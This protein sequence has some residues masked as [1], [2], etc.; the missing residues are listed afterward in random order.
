MGRLLLWAL[1][2]LTLVLAGVFLFFP[3][4]AYRFS[5]RVWMA[6]RHLNQTLHYGLGYQLPGTPDLK[7]LDPRLAEKGFKRGAPIFIRIIKSELRLE[8]W[9]KRGERF[10]KFASYPICYWSGRLGPKLKTGDHQAPEGFYTVSRTQLNPNS[11][12]HRSFNL[13]FPN[14][15]DRMKGRTGSYLM[16]HGG[17]SSAGCYAMTNGVVSELWDLIN[18]ALDAGQNRFAVHIFPFRLNEARLNAYRRNRWSEFWRS[19]KPG[20]D[21]FEQTHIP[22]EI[23]LCKGTYSAQRGK[24]NRNSAIALRE[25]CPP[26]EHL[27][28]N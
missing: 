19:L 7:R 1:I 8:L 25:Y 6:T 16:V 3:G 28:R 26:M 20:Y 21:L 10:V 2:C 11:R 4:T 17:C 12:W 22:P 15:Y 23:S 18:A 14:L 24:A 13:G 5:D 27:A 9:M